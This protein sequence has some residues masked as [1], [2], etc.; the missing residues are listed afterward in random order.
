MLC[1]IAAFW[2]VS[3]CNDAPGPV[4]SELVPTD[5]LTLKIIT[6]DSLPLI[7]SSAIGQFSPKMT[8]ELNI[9]EPQ[10]LPPQ[11][12]FIGAARV[13]GGDEFTAA[14]Y[15]R[16]QIPVLNDSIRRVN[17]MSLTERDIIDAQLFVRPSTSLIGDTISKIAPFRVYEIRQRW[18]NDNIT[19]TSNIPNPQSLITQ[20]FVAQYAQPSSSFG[21]QVLFDA[22]PVLSR[23]RPLAILDKAMIVRWIKADT[24]TWKD[25]IF[26]LGFVPRI[27]PVSPAAQVLF[28]FEES[29]YIVVRYRRAQDSTENFLTISEDAQATITTCPLPRN[30]AAHEIIVQGGVA[31]RSSLNFDIRTIPPLSTIHQAE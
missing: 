20:P 6:N 5:S 28:G 27:S 26:G 19:R 10:G 4:G 18:Y 29:S 9:T 22:S 8:T 30:P 13:S 24:T 15:I 7:V 14:A 3:A 1:C 21:G 2:G 31:L 17:F 12:F 16:Y 11:P 23:K 25:S